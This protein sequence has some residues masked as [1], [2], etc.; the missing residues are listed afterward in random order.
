MSDLVGLPLTLNFSSY[1]AAKEIEIRKIRPK[2][3]ANPYTNS[4]KLSK[5]LEIPPVLSKHIQPIANQHSE[6]L[7]RVELGGTDRK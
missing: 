2:T 4:A 3:L 6:V 7:I 1:V 5:M